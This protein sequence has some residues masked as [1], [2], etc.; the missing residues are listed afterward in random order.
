[1]NIKNK[2]AE[3]EKE[4]EKFR[5]VKINGRLNL[6][7]AKL[8]EIKYREVQLAIWKEVEQQ[9]G[10][11]ISNLNVYSYKKLK[12]EDYIKLENF[13]REKVKEIFFAEEHKGLKVIDGNPTAISEYLRE[14]K[15]G[16][17]K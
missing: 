14:R 3:L 4:I 10:L 11:F 6:G 5:G 8:H 13:V 7:V 2:I 1:M 17:N 16:E 15:E 9:V 12:S